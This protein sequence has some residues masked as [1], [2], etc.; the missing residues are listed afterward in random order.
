MIYYVLQRFTS[1]FLDFSKKTPGS[2]LKFSFLR[3]ISGRHF[4]ARC[5]FKI[6]FSPLYIKQIECIF[7]KILE[8]MLGGGLHFS[9]FLKIF[10]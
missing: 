3:E 2:Y 6:C 10:A 4:R 5:F 7:L 8:K 9:E 1:Y